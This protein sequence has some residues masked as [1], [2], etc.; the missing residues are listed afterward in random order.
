[1]P[2]VPLSQKPNASG[3]PATQRLEAANA[4]GRELRPASRQGSDDDDPAPPAG[5][6]APAVVVAF[7]HVPI[8]LSLPADVLRRGA[9]EIIA[10][11]P[12]ALDV[13]LNKVVAEDL[14][15]PI[16]GEDD[17][18]KRAGGVADLAA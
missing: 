5:V 7:E 17:G 10:A 16:F 18:R 1:C 6:V 2:A 8:A 15:L 4:H 14:G 13:G 3:K 11:G 9:A 12:H